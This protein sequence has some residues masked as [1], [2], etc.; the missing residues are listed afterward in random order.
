MSSSQGALPDDFIHELVPWLDRSTLASAR[1]VSRQW[2]RIA[3]ARLMERLSFSLYSHT[4]ASKTV[5]PFHVLH[6]RSS[7][8]LRTAEDQECDSRSAK[9]GKRLLQFFNTIASALQARLLSDGALRHWGPHSFPFVKELDLTGIGLLAPHATDNLFDSAFP[10]HL[11]PSECLGIQHLKNIASANGNQA[12]TPRSSLVFQPDADTTC[13]L[14]DLFPKLPMLAALKLRS[15]DLAVVIALLSD[16]D[17]KSSPTPRFKHL[18]VLELSRC[19]APP[20]GSE[21]ARRL[22]EAALKNGSLVHFKNLSTISTS[23]CGTHCESCRLPE[24]VLSSVVGPHVGNA[25]RSITFGDFGWSSLNEL[26]EAY[27]LTSRAPNVKELLMVGQNLSSVSFSYY[28]DLN[29]SMVATL[30]AYCPNLT[31]LS[32]NV[33]TYDSITDISL[34]SLMKYASGRLR[35]LLFHPGT[36]PTDETLLELLLNQPL[37]ESVQLPACVSERTL[38]ICLSKCRR[39]RNLSIGGGSGNPVTPTALS[40]IGRQGTR[41]RALRVRTRGLRMEWIGKTLGAPS[42]RLR[43]GYWL[44]LGINVTGASDESGNAVTGLQQM[45]P[46]ASVAK[47]EWDGFELGPIP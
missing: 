5:V 31:H 23:T 2:D 21:H 45:L 1:L 38:M 14:L 24:T 28:S 16:P 15:L 3:A 39:L 22:A 17:S 44:D 19:H 37:L 42:C 26:Q 20:E 18:Q 46:D 34:R 10:G 29:D 27:S 6:R 36:R 13:R 11:R 33:V 32:L 35:S 4:E 43:K 47:L 30:A 9:N 8:S 25:L 7:R 40:W 41:L 12:Q